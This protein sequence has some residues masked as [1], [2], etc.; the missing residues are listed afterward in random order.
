MAMFLVSSMK[1]KEGSEIDKPD[2]SLSSQSKKIKT[3]LVQEEE[4]EQLLQ[5]PPGEDFNQEDQKLM[6]SDDEMQTE[7]ESENGVINYDQI[8]EELMDVEDESASKTGTGDDALE[9]K[10]QL[11]VLWPGFF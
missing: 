4:Q 1:R 6:V 11:P 5:N 2:L 8:M 7:H 9:Q 3:V 10:H